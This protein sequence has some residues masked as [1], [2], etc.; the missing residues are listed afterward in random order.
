MPIYRLLK[1]NGAFGPEATKAMS[2]AF[3]DVL[4]ELNL[5]D[6]TDPKVE[7]VALKIIEI[8]HRGEFDPARIRELVLKSIRAEG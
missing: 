1:M 7:I 2:T 6:R 8:G 4:R 3:E 5:T